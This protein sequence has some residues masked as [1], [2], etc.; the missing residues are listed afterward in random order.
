MAALAT[1]CG[2]ADQDQAHSAAPFHLDR[3]SQMKNGPPSRAVTTPTGTSAGASATRATASHTARNAAPSEERARQQHPVIG[4]DPQAQR[5]GH[6]QPDEADR[7][8][9]RC[10]RRRQQRPRDIAGQE[11]RLHRHTARRGPILADCHQ[12]PVRSAR[13]HNGNR[14]DHQ[15]SQPAERRVLRRS[16]SRPSTSV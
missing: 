15:E 6:D 11:Q 12:I 8:R 10:H 3:S 9:D 16:R 1:P 14:W 7:P 5:V 4:A 2:A 13:Q